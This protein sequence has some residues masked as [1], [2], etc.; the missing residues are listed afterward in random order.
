MEWYSV[1]RCGCVVWCGAVRCGAVCGVAWCDVVW[2]GV[3]WCGAVRCGAPPNANC[4]LPL[5][6]CHW[7]PAPYNLLVYLLFA[8]S[9]DLVFHLRQ[10]V[11]PVVGSGVCDAVEDSAVFKKP[12]IHNLSYIPP[13]AYSG[14]LQRRVRG[15]IGCDTLLT[16]NGGLV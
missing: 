7:P 2:C 4:H 11:P 10:M 5:A 16:W 13:L 1:V 8:H 12:N 6:T 3:V 15:E 9:D 14:V